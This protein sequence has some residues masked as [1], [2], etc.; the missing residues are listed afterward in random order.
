MTTL[1]SVR[2]GIKYQVLRLR[3]LRALLCE[4]PFYRHLFSRGYVPWRHI[5]SFELRAQTFLCF[6]KR[7]RSA[8]E[9]F[10]PAILM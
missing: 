7:L 3:A 5:L 1:V 2:E 6:L 9:R 10:C 8:A 4:L